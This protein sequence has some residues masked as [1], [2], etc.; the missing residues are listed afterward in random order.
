MVA[1]ASEMSN[2]VETAEKHFSH[3]IGLERAHNTEILPDPS[4]AA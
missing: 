2:K 3:I 4:I 1:R